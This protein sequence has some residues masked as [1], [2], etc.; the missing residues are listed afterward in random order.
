M[1]V[2]IETRPQPRPRSRLRTAILVTLV[3]HLLGAAIAL[4]YYPKFR[5]PLTGEI[6][7]AEFPSANLDET[8]DPDPN[9]KPA[10]TR[11]DG[12][13]N[14]RVEKKLLDLVDQADA[15][16]PVEN[17]TLLAKEAAKLNKISNPE[18]LDQLLPVLSDAMKLKARATAPADSPP[19]GLFEAESAVF[20]KV[21]RETDD[22]GD[23]HYFS[24]LLDAEGRTLGIELD[25]VEGESVYRTMR[26]VE[27]NPLLDSVYRKFVIPAMDRAKAIHSPPAKTP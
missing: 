14:Q 5:A 18:S 21:R 23:Y 19:D 1:N 8:T 7:S 17:Q 13:W 6:A 12:D 20:H 9:P 3:L 16:T 25:D 24:V 10:S 15:R 11:Q 22:K 4:F 27:Q 26:L 2:D